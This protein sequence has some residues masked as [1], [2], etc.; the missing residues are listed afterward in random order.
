MIFVTTFI[1]SIRY[2]QWLSFYLI[3]CEISVS[4]NSQKKQNFSP[5]S[6][7]KLFFLKRNL[8]FFL[9][10]LYCLS[11]HASHNLKFFLGLFHYLN[12]LKYRSSGVIRKFLVYYQSRVILLRLK[13]YPRSVKFL[14]YPNFHLLLRCG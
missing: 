14:C 6:Y 9:N 5:L 1:T 11:R 8:F 13:W 2:A 10:V 12:N 7:R 4:K 3:K